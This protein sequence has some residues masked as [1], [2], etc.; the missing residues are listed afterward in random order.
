MI[1]IF[2]SIN[3]LC[4]KRIER[5]GAQYYIFAI[6]GIINYPLAYIYGVYFSGL[7]ETESSTLRFI[8]TILCLGLLFRK[9][10]PD[11]IKTYLP[12]YW[13]FAV[14]ICIPFLTT[15]LLF[16]N[17]ISLGW[18]MHYIVGLM[19]LILIADWIMCIILTVVGSS[20]AVAAFV[21]VH[22][23]YN[24]DVSYDNIGLFLYMFFCILILCSIF[25]RNREIHENY[26]LQV[27]EGINEQLEKKVNEVNER[28]S[29]LTEKTE[30]LNAALTTRNRFLNNLSHEVR[31]PIHGVLG[32]SD[33]LYNVWDKLEDA[34]KYELSRMIYVNA[35]RLASLVNNVLD[36]SRFNLNK[37]V[38]EYKEADLVYLIQ[39]MIEECNELYLQHNPN[40]IELKFIRP[41]NL[42]EA[43]IIGDPNRLT[44][45]LRNLL[46]NSIF[47]ATKG[48]R[49]NLIEVEISAKKLTYSDE[50]VESGYLV[51]VTDEGVGIPEDEMHKIFES[52]YETTRTATMVGGTAI[53]LA[54]VQ[55]IITAH[56]G[57]IWAEN[58]FIIGSKISFVLPS[59]QNKCTKETHIIHYE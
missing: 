29:E 18:L 44:Q 56:Y 26:L 51:S 42:K 6:F 9:S 48:A 28:T 36:L 39:D 4:K 45:V 19:I 24:F 2:K 37:I 46:G 33:C 8:A 14:T 27:K 38:L 59:S 57:I 10:W 15:Y 25:S 16:L 23:K 11:K 32:L 35:N 41:K 55:S 22:H 43:W 3:N 7:A 34:K 50:S 1:N 20:T 17:N 13:Y 5:F 12:L 30:Q 21:L 40:K 53:G 31:L 47:Y 52:F 49:R 54:I 58:N